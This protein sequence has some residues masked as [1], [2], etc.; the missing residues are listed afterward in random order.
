[1]ELYHILNRGVEKIPIVRDNRDRLR[2]VRDLYEMNDARPVTNLWYRAKNPF[3]SDFVNHYKDERERLVDIHGWCLM[4]NHY[5]LLVS[6]VQSGGLTMFLRKLNIGY[7]NYFNER[8]HRSGS[9]YQGRTKKVLIERDAHFLWILNYIHLNPLDFMRTA[10]DWRAQCLVSEKKALEYLEG[11]RWSSYRDYLGEGEFAPILAGSFMFQ[12]KEEHVRESR[13]Y[14]A[15][16]AATP[17]P[18]HELE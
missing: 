1:M 9:L 15:S 13:Q 17:V 6:E 2:F 10:G 14:L 16:I 5:H 12:D 8:H 7:A 4:G 11:Y 3:S 18:L